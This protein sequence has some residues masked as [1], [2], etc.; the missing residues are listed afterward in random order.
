ME[1]AG[2]KKRSPLPDSA[3]QNFYGME[4]LPALA[5]AAG[6][7]ATAAAAFAT[8]AAAATRTISAAAAATA[9]VSTTTTAAAFFT[10]TGFVDFDGAAIELLA[11][12]PLHRG[13]AFG[14]A[15]HGDEGKTARAVRGTIHHDFAI[16][17]G[18]EFFERVLQIDFSGIEREI[19]YEESHTI[20]FRFRRL[21]ECI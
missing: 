8:L 1:D 17:D 16:R 3:L 7:L 15:A 4:G 21:T 13:F 18:A 12:E 10:R 20:W 2:K 5:V 9:A 6:A 19:S 14:G 11:V